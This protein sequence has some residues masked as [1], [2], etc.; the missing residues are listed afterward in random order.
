MR[1]SGS[2]TVS[3]PM[4]FLVPNQGRPSAT[5]PRFRSWRPLAYHGPVRAVWV[6]VVTVSAAVPAW[7]ADSG[8]SLLCASCHPAQAARHRGSAHAQ[9]LSRA[10]AVHADTLFDRPVRERTGIEFTYQAAKDG[11]LVSARQGSSEPATAVLEWIFGAGVLA[12]TPVGRYDGKYFEHRVSHYSAPQRPALTLG[13]GGVPK[14][15][16]AALGLSQTADTIF[17]CFNCHATGVK[18]GPDLSQINPGVHC[19]RCHGTSESHVQNPTLQN[20]RKWTDVTAAESVG[21]CAEC[22]RA[23]TTAESS[24]PPEQLDP[25]SV[26]FA[27]V[28][29]TASKCFQVSGKLACVTC[30]DPHG[31]PRP[32]RSSIEGK[33]QGCHPANTAVVS[34][35]PRPQDTSCLSCHMQQTTPAPH[36]T[37]TDHRIRVYPPTRR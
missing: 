26:R 14:S 35:C 30:H 15:S 1:C 16:A 24:R 28:G 7:T 10:T 19:Q 31:G 25:L 22:H 6:L 23:P 12:V 18:P 5:L 2:K 4:K 17:R 21:M 37:F 27:P 3:S 13:H 20:V 33:C 32:S 36:L 34:A 9:A 11:L 8:P 29:L